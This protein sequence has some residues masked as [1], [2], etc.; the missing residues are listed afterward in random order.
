MRKHWQGI[1]VMVN[2][3][4]LSPM[5][6]NLYMRT[7]QASSCGQGCTPTNVCSQIRNTTCYN[8][9][10]DCST[11]YDTGWQDI[12]TGVAAWNKT[13]DS[14]SQL[15]DPIDVNCFTH[16]QCITVFQAG[17]RCYSGWTSYY[18]TSSDGFD[19]QCAQQGTGPSV[20]EYY[21]S[22]QSKPCSEQG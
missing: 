7:A 20:T 4:F 16:A 1:F 22:C 11:G 5:L 19:S 21:P 6:I 12:Y 14:S 13:G 3:L 2:V 8:P 15:S 9:L 17:Q 10:N 18:C